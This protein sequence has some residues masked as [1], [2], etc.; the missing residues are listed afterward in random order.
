MQT[1]IAL[2]MLAAVVIPMIFALLR[3][4][5]E[6]FTP[7]GND[8]ASTVGVHQGG[9]RAGYYDG[10]VPIVSP[11]TGGT[12]R[13]LLMIQ[14][15]ADNHYNLPTSVTQMPIAVCNDEPGSATETYPFQHL[16]GTDSTVRM[17]ASGAISAGQL[18]VTA[19]NGQVSALGSTPGIY[20]CVGVAMTS[21]TAAGD[22][23]EVM[24]T[25]LPAGV[26]VIT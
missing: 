4:R 3:L 14:G 26:N 10:T 18:V 15:S 19:G 13:F 17:Q 11:T 20:W 12:G 9:R 8:G 7:L 1:L 2:L 24:P 21:T 23:L 25:L 16:L 5:R 6:K 22:L